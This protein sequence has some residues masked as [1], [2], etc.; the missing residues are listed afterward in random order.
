MS[1]QNLDSGPFNAGWLLEAA[2]AERIIAKIRIS[3]WFLTTVAGFVQAWSFRFVISPD[4]NS[5]LDVASAY[6][7]SDYANAINGA[8]SPMVS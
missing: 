3:F 7:R 6:M 8:W 4:G 1:S 5:Y 2:D